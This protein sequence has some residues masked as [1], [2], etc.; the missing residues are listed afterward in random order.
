MVLWNDFG[1][2]LRKSIKHVL[3]GDQHREDGG[4]LKARQSLRGGVHHITQPDCLSGLP[5]DQTQ[6]THPIA[7]RPSMMILNLLAMRSA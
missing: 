4:R 5:C 1:S 2:S 7:P 6:A 3:A